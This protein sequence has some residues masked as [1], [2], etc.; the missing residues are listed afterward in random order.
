M[1]L[2]VSVGV[3]MYCIRFRPRAH[4]PK[5]TTPTD[6]LASRPL[7]Q[8]SVRVG[9]LKAMLSLIPVYSEGNRPG[10]ARQVQ[11]QKTCAA[12]LVRL[13]GTI[14]GTITTRHGTGVEDPMAS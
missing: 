13:H 12:R 4:M 1:Y 3:H 9:K 14:T 5:C 8:R 11:G 10:R 6:R 2:F 7:V